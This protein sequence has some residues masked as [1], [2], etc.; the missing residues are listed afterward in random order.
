MRYSV[1]TLNNFSVELVYFSS[2]YSF[3]FVL[4]TIGNWRCYS[5]VVFYMC[6]VYFEVKV[7]YKMSCCKKNRCFCLVLP[8]FKCPMITENKHLLRDPELST[9]T[10]NCQIYIMLLD[11]LNT[12]DFIPYAIIVKSI[13]QIKAWLFV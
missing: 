1:K 5:T 4:Y 13:T 6:F 2:H 12:F 10:R 9:V 8:L 11:T 3:C 7:L